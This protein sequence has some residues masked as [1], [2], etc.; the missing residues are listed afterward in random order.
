MGSGLVVKVV[1]FQDCPRNW[2]LSGC[3]LPLCDVINPRVSLHSI[4]STF[5]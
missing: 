5:L 1:A 3:C 2:P 4:V